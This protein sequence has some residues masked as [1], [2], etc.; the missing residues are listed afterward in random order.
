[1]QLCSDNIERDIEELIAAK[2]T[3]GLIQERR[4]EAIDQAKARV[5]RLPPRSHSRIVAQKELCEMMA[6]QIM[7]EVA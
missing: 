7:R 2:F 5:C 3:P 6:R 1:M 4:M